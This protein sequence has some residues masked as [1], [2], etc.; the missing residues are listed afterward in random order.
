MFFTIVACIDSKTDLL[1]TS[2]F[3]KNGFAD[4]RYCAEAEFET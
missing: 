1:I 4:R 3:K 2:S